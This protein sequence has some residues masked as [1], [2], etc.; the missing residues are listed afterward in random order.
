MGKM[1]ENFWIWREIR[2]IK[3]EIRRYEPY[4]LKVSFVK[5]DDFSVVI[6]YKT[7]N[8]MFCIYC[9]TMF[10]EQQDLFCKKLEQIGFVKDD[11]PSYESLL[12]FDGSHEIR[13]NFVPVA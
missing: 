6:L 12:P 1:S 8:E 7:S 4:V 3:K 11:S 13:V 9:S 5:R 2:Q 10:F